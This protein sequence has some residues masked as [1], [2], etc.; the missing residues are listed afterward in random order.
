[1]D[2]NVTNVTKLSLECILLMVIVFLQNKLILSYLDLILSI[3]EHWNR[4]GNTNMGYFCNKWCNTRS[5]VWYC[6][7]YVSF[8]PID[9]NFSGY[10][11]IYVKKTILRPR[12]RKSHYLTIYGYKIVTMLLNYL[13]TAKYKSWMYFNQRHLLLAILTPFSQILKAG[14]S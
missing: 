7:N 4:Q 10:M 3:I 14:I 6:P 5:Y 2:T 1:M 12:S 8:G 11:P 9:L 13:W